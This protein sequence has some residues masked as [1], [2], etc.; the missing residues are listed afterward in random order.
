MAPASDPA[1]LHD[2]A[3][4]SLRF[5][6]DTMARAADFTAVSGAGGVAMGIT[7][8]I[9]AWAAG[10]PMDDVRWLTYWLLDAAVA[11]AIGLMATFLKARRGGTPLPLAAN[12]MRDAAIAFGGTPGPRTAAD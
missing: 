3:A 1:A 10:P 5:I 2:Q 12:R 6:R 11:V 7:A 8:L 4:E 9:T